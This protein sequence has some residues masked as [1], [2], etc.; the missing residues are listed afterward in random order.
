MDVT[1]E[2][3]GLPARAA[4][5][6]AFRAFLAIDLPASVRKEIGAVIARLKRSGADVKW[7]KA[8]NL[9]LTLKFLGTTPVAA[10]GTLEAALR[11]ALRDCAPFGLRLEGLGA[12]PAKDKP[13]VVW[14]GLAEGAEALGALAKRVEETAVEAG[15]R[16]ETRPYVPHLTLG[17]VRSLKNTRA[18]AWELESP[19]ASRETFT[20][21]RVFLYRSVLQP[22]GAVYERVFEIPF[23]G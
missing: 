8:E 10:A 2:E 3:D 22:E 16:P 13:R 9:H 15:F 12:F 1:S 4:E 18:L 20:A 14:A 17:R 23:G 11:G 7:A 21:D 19:F 6:G 5:A